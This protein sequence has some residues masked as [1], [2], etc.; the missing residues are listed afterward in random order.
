MPKDRV[1]TGFGPTNLTVI[2]TG[3]AT[4]AGT[5]VQFGPITGKNLGIMATFSATSAGQSV[6]LQGLMGTTAST[7]ARN[8]AQRKSSQKTLFT[9]GTSSGVITHVRINSTKIKAVA[10]ATCTVIVAAVSP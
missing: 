9:M 8:I 5:W 10:G 6:W 1:I 2:S 3:A 4:K 7:N